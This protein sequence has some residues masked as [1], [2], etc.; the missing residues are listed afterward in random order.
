MT[1]DQ[2]KFTA[3]FTLVALWAA[4]VFMKMA[5]P[6]ALLDFIKVTL[7][8]IVG[9]WS[10][11]SQAASRLVP[12][13]VDVKQVGQGGFARPMLLAL[14]AVITGLS[15]LAGCTTTT[16]SAYQGLYTQ[17]KAGVMVFDDN[18]LKTA[19]DIICAQPYSSIQRNADM[20]AG[21]LVLCGPLANVSS[22]DANQLQLLLNVM[23]S[24]GISVAPAAAAAPAPASAASAAK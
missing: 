4:F 24:A 5:S 8:A 12:A 6:D 1:S 11:S 20:Q 2:M 15:V 17:A 18:A 16:A 14:I 22:L 9:H 23:K 3:A 7:G 21:I 13:A 10:G 19:R